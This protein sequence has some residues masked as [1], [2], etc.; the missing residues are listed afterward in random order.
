MS[1]AEKSTLINRVLISIQAAL[2]AFDLWIIDVTVEGKAVT[3]RVLLWQLTSKTVNG[4]LFI[5]VIILKNDSNG[6][7]CLSILILSTIPVMEWIWIGWLPITGCKVNSN[8]DANLTPSKNIVEERLFLIDV[9][10]C[11][12][13]S[14]LWR[15]WLDRWARLHVTIGEEKLS[16]HFV[17]STWTVFEHWN[18]NFPFFFVVGKQVRISHHCIPSKSVFEYF[19]A[20]TFEKWSEWSARLLLGKGEKN[21]TVAAL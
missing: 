12:K 2:D 4:V 6:L 1:R 7:K 21:L 19:F 13:D 5:R 11:D 10:L 15:R 9:Y 8:G 17:L 20:L 16:D 3:H 18:F 14:S